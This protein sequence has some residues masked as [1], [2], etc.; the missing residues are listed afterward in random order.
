MGGDEELLP[1][2]P[3]HLRAAAPVHEGL[4]GQLGRAHAG[5]RAPVGRVVE[6]GEGGL[7]KGL[8]YDTL[9]QPVPCQPVVRLRQDGLG[10][11]LRPPSVQLQDSAGA[12]RAV[13]QDQRAVRCRLVRGGGRVRILRPLAGQEDEHDLFHRVTVVMPLEIELHA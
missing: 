10:R 12:G 13:P 8:F 1:E 2:H 4:G 11:A 5:E 7:V 9:A 6:Q 3:L